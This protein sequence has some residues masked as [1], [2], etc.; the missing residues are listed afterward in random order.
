MTQ[1]ALNSVV[2]GIQFFLSETS[3]LIQIPATRAHLSNLLFSF[4]FQSIK[5]HFIRMYILIWDLSVNWEFV[6][7]LQ[8]LSSLPGRIV[9]QTQENFSRALVLHKN[10]SLACRVCLLFE[11][12]IL[13]NMRTQMQSAYFK[14][15]TTINFSKQ[16]ILWLEIEFRFHVI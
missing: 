11:L 15:W 4:T 10:C 6:T 5:P 16:K 12:W 14:K 3:L 9:H 1:I 13:V 8:D 2:L 7:E